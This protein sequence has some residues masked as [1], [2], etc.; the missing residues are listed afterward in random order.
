MTALLAMLLLGDCQCLTDGTQEIHGFKYINDGLCS[1]E[2]AYF[3]G[4]VRAYPGK[5]LAL[6]GDRTDDVPAVVV[7]N[8]A[9]RD[10]GTAFEVRRGPTHDDS[11]LEVTNYGDVSL[12]C[13]S[14]GSTRECR[15]IDATGVSGH[16]SLTCMP[17]YYVTVAG[18]LAENHRGQLADGG[19]TPALDAGGLLEVDGGTYYPFTALHGELT[20]VASEARPAGGWLAEWS[21][22]VTDGTNVKRAFVDVWGGFG[23]RHQMIRAQFPKCPADE[24]VTA[25]GQHYFNGAIES[26]QLYAFDE[27]RWYFCNGS[28]WVTK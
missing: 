12:S 22:P 13:Q 3:N 1:M 25:E 5:Q 28:E 20:V 8:F 7:G 26:T 24:F 6:I 18:R 17:R 21:N 11:I 23:Q 2:D 14:V 19:A 27:H 4:A 16:W 10:A 9:R 15:F